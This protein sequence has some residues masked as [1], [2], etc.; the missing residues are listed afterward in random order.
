MHRDAER[1]QY[2]R[3]MALDPMWM[4]HAAMDEGLASETAFDA[5]LDK[6]IAEWKAGQQDG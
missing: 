5:A 2:W 3:A 1:Y 4:P 6:D